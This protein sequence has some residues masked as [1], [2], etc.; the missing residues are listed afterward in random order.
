MHNRSKP[1]FLF[2]MPSSIKKIGLSSFSVSPC[3]LPVFLLRDTFFSVSIAAGQNNNILDFLLV[4]NFKKLQY[5]IITML[6]FS[7][8]WEYC[9]LRTTWWYVCSFFDLQ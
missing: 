9:D 2:E 6:P 8:W 4:Y 1:V 5:I 3:L 7:K